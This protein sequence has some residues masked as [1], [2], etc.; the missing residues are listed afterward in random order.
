LTG[1][2]RRFPNRCARLRNW[3]TEREHVPG[4]SVDMVSGACFLARRAYL[5]EVD[6]FDEELFLYEEETDLMLPAR[7]RGL[8]TVY[9]PEAV[10]VHHGGASVAASGLSAFATRHLYRSKYYCFRKHYGRRAARRAYRLDRAVL[11]CSATRQ[12]LRG[13]GGEAAARLR[14]VR[15][16]WRES[17]TPLAV[18]RARADFH[19]S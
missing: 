13:P 9:C 2:E 19:D 1:M 15:R 8:K 3:L 4:A 16:A 5:E 11:V 7:R 10:V 6:G 18:L 14:E 17:F 12:R